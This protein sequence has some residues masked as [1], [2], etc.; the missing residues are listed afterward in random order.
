[1]KASKRYSQCIEKLDQTKS[2]SI[3][4]AVTALKELVTAKFD[5]TV[6][7]SCKLGADPKKSDQMIRG[8]VVLPNG[9]GKKVKVA[10]FCEAEKEQ[11]AKDAGA[12]FVGGQELIEKIQKEN[13]L[14]FD[15]CVATPSMMKFVSRL[16]KLLGPRGLMPS[17]KT[18]SVTDNIA[19][20]VK[21]AKAGKVE[22][23]MNKLG[24]LSAG[25][26]KISF[27]QKAIIENIKVMVDALNSS[28]PASVKGDLIKS[29]YLSTTMSPSVKVKL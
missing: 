5:E 17:P 15:S 12:D 20:A 4:E 16:G 14:D 9:T 8:S 6:E 1:M 19:N 7:I 27:S 24:G 3:D 28:K 29:I 18:G 11:D 26:G 22:F 10:V 23:R 21:E 13:W 25:V 2:Y